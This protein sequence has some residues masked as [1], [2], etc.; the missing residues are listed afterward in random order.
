MVSAPLGIF[1][2]VP[3]RAFCSCTIRRSADGPSPGTPKLSWILDD[4]QKKHRTN[5][6]RRRGRKEEGEDN[7]H[8]NF[9]SSQ[10]SGVEHYPPAKIMQLCRSCRRDRLGPSL[11]VVFHPGSVSDGPRARKRPPDAANDNKQ[12]YKRKRRNNRKLHCLCRPL[13][14]PA[15]RP[16][17]I[18]KHS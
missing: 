8:G 11:G 7:G 1:K 17:G 5:R 16:S 9:N 4:G 13:Q 2:A 3:P 14:S 15:E 18:L 12:A 6:T 10:L